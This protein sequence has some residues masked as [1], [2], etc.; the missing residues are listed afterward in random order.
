MSRK[1]GGTE[2]PRENAVL[3]AGETIASSNF[4]VHHPSIA[5]L[6][7]AYSQQY[8]VDWI[9]TLSVM[10]QESRFDDN[11]MSDK[12][13]YGLMQ[14]MP[15]TQ[16]ELAEKLD[17][18]EAASPKN[19][20][21]AG[22]YHLK[23]LKKIFEKASPKDQTCLALAAYNC[24]LG[25][26]LDAQ[27]I[28]EYMGNNPL[29]WES[30]RTALVF[31]SRKYYTLHKKIWEEGVPS[32]GYFRDWRQTVTYVDEVMKHYDDYSLAMK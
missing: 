13:A 17:V 23:S 7:R 31:L 11:A 26:I 6:V 30:V 28:A 20:L 15:L 12:G 16:L 2:N 25:R 32:S 27:K 22:I 21:R 24:G 14:L 5:P 1:S 29:K 19:N 4:H 9:L 10:R 8:G 3:Y 18:D